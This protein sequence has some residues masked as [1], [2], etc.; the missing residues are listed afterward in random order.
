MIDGIGTTM[1]FS[2]AADGNVIINITDATNAEITNV[3][4]VSG[5]AQLQF[6]ITG[7]DDYTQYLFKHEGDSDN[8]IKLSNTDGNHYNI[9]GENVNVTSSGGNAERTIQVDAVSSKIDLTRGSGS[10]FVY[11]SNESQD[12]KVTLG[13]G[14]DNYIDAGKFNNAQDKGGTNRLETTFESHGAVIVGGGG[15]DT[16]VIGGK[17]GVI[18]GG[19]G[20]N[21]FEAVGIFGENGEASY[22]NIIIGGSGDDTLIDKGGYNIFFG[23]EGNNTY[24]SYGTCG[25]AQLGTNGDGAGIFGS[26]AEKT[27][28]FTGEEVTSSSGTTYSIY[29]VMK[30]FN[31]SLSDFINVYSQISEENPDSIGNHDVIDEKTMSKLEEYFVNNP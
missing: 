14:S 5:T 9:V 28:V 3:G 21:T 26:S 6:G 23:G 22:R 27:Y 1:R 17:Y 16:F 15:N 8:E 4:T 30:K 7:E 19:N 25:I 18:D 24:E 12:N 31:W 13:T 11:M 29:E 10:Q 20:S 2:R